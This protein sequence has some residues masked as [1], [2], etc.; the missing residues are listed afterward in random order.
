MF[1]AFSISTQT[2]FEPEQDKKKATKVHSGHWNIF[3]TSHPTQVRSET[4]ELEGG[5]ESEK[6]V[7]GGMEKKKSHFLWFS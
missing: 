1:G 6:E 2:L 5:V 7:G 3:I 4:K